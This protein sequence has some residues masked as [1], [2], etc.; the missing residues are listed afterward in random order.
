LTFGRPLYSGVNWVQGQILGFLLRVEPWR[1]ARNTTWYVFSWRRGSSQPLQITDVH[2]KHVSYDHFNP[3][4]SSRSILEAMP[5]SN[6]DVLSNFFEFRSPPNV[7][8]K[9][10]SQCSP[11]NYTINTPP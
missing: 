8:N 2:T 6:V 7:E 5:V 3:F 1:T 10:P 4:V 11:P 9:L